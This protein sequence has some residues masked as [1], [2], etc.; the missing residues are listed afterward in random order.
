MC[1]G[2]SGQ[3]LLPASLPT[4]LPPPWD[5]LKTPFERHDSQQ[6][7]VHI[8]AYSVEYVINTIIEKKNKKK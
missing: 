8:P 7:C 3:G 2:A 6:C 4:P 1:G 5:P